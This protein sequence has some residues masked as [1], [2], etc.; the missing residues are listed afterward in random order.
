M[1][2]A[3]PARTENPTSEEPSAADLRPVFPISLCLWTFSMTTVVL[4]TTIPTAKDRPSMLMLFMVI[5]MDFRTTM[6][7]SRHTGIVTTATNVALMVRRNRNM[8]TDVIIIPIM[9]SPFTPLM[10]LWMNRD[11]SWTTSRVT[12]LGAV[13]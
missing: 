11:E 6:L 8:M 9:I 4:S 1:V 2:V 13:A 12:P 10:D 7:P 5:P 3:A